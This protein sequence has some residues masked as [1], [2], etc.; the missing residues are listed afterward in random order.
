M[1]AQEQ[2]WIVCGNEISD[3]DAIREAKRWATFC[4]IA[5]INTKLPLQEIVILSYT[6]Y[7]FDKCRLAQ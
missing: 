6:N 7:G 5:H 3:Y 2:P 1:I 4:V